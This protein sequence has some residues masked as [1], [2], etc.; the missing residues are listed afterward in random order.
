LRPVITL[1][2]VVVEVLSRSRLRAV[3]FGTR[4]PLSTHPG[5]TS[6]S[7]GAGSFIALLSVQTSALRRRHQRPQP[8][9]RI[10]L[11]ATACEPRTDASPRRGTRSFGRCGPA[12]IKASRE[13]HQAR[14]RPRR[15]DSFSVGKHSCGAGRQLLRAGGWRAEANRL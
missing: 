10:R 7:A 6:T 9:R 13:P 2:A 4:P 3:S 12:E 11:W 1:V 5:I 8:T 14:A 15:C